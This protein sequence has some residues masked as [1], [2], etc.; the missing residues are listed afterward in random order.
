MAES[1]RISSP[2]KVTSIEVEALDVRVKSHFFNRQQR[3]TGG[4]R[5]KVTGMSDS[6]RS[7]LVQ[8]ARNLTTFHGFVTVTYPGAEW[9]AT[10]AGDYMTDGILVKQHLR[11]LRRWF[12]YHGYGALWFLEFQKRGAPHFHFFTDKPLSD[13]DTYKISR[14]WYRLVGSSCPNHLIHGTDCQVLR[15]TFAAGMYAAKYSSKSEQKD[16]PEQY[17]NVGRFWG[18]FN[19]EEKP[20]YKIQLTSMREIYELARIAKNSEKAHRRSQGLN[21]RKE[22]NHHSAIR[23]SV[24]ASVLF[25]L[26]SRYTILG[27]PQ[28]MRIL[29][30]ERHNPESS[31]PLWGGNAATNAPPF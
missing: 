15:E 19:I 9:S 8:K 24:A 22:K 13:A 18:V 30:L 2:S 17:L 20:L 11:K 4:L 5:G 1:T 29:A 23:Y 21:R 31:R 6:S 16:V 14:Y 28:R 12:T 10:A 7:R 25:Y 27:N 3:C 26:K